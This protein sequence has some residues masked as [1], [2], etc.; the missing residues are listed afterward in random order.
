MKFYAEDHI[1]FAD[2]NYIGGYEMVDAIWNSALS[3]WREIYKFDIKSHHIHL[4][5]GEAAS[6]LVEIEHERIESNGDTTKLTGSGS[7]G[8]QKFPDG[9]KAVTQS[10][11]HNHLEGYNPNEK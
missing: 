7:Y 6:Y 11:V 3:N 8:M 4:F 5:S 9:W 10:V 2:G 1:V